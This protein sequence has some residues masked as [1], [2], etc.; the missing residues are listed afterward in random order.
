MNE[1]SRYLFLAGALPFVL[2]GAAHVRATP[3]RI[4]DGKGLSPSDPQL[5]EA[6]TKASPLLTSRTSMWLAWVGFNLS[7]SLGAMTLGGFVL[8]TGRDAAR[9][10]D[11]A[12]VCVPFAVLVAAAY[13]WIA[14]RYW[15]RIPI[16]GCALS[17][18]LFLASWATLLLGWP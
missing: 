14:V 10:A 1:L 15:F 18:A 7:H 16:V 4:G 12:S 2:L 6:M 5:A 11:Q 17:L 9:F 8:L 13:L 3:A